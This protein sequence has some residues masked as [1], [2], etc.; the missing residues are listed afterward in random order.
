LPNWKSGALAWPGI[1]DPGQAGG[2]SARQSPLKDKA[3]SIFLDQNH[4]L[5]HG[6]KMEF[7]LRQKLVPPNGPFTTAMPSSKQ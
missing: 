7:C 6:P 5:S 3:F 2:E 4:R 1:D